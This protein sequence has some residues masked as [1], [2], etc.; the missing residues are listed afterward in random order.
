MLLQIC[1]G[2]LKQPTVTKNKTIECA[3][4]CWPIDIDLYNHMNNANYLRVAELAR[5][6]AFPGSGLFDAAVKKGI[7]F[8]AV[9]QSIT[10]YKP[11]PSFGKY[12]VATSIDIYKDDKWIWYTHTFLQHPDNVKV[13]QE[14]RKYAEIKLRAVVKEKS[15]KTIKPS[16][17]LAF[18]NAS[19]LIKDLW[20]VHPDEEKTI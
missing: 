2:Y 10:Y 5:W 15:G 13:G 11:V 12:V 16:E 8:L 7:M 6:N 3:F 20:N 1:K 9:E 18:P 19:Q 17:Q 4:R 14:A